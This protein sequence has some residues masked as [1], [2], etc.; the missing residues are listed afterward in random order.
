VSA[1]ARAFR[2]LFECAPVGLAAVDLS[3][4]VVAA[5]P[6]L[7]HLLGFSESALRGRAITDLTYPDDL[8]LT[9]QL[10][11]ELGAGLRASYSVEKRY[12]RA[13]G[14]AVKV[15]VTALLV[16]DP[17][18]G[19]AFVVGL[20]EPL[21]ELAQL[22][23]S[24]AE[25]RAT[26]HDFNN[27]LFVIVNYAEL[28]LRQLPAGE[29]ARSEVEELRDAAQKATALIRRVFAVRDTEPARAETLDVNKVILEMR[30]LAQNLVGSNIQI[31]LRLDPSN[32]RV[33]AER[34]GFERVL[35]NIAANSRDAM[36]SGGTFSVETR[37]TGGAVE[38]V[39]SDTGPGIEPE[40]R[41]RIFDRGVTTKTAVGG[42]GIGLANVRDYAEAAGGTIEVESQP[43]HGATF[44]LTL[45][46]VV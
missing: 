16:R 32:P 27:L 22:Q 24:V 43:G 44:T 2:T 38:I 5:N 12:V 1:Q 14:A 26:A 6:A 42:Q 45:P 4:Q 34:E 28:L 23:E 8:A 25:A 31:V 10:F 35:G 39:M 20:V 19:R 3:G 13:D 21:D 36:P 37:R 40:I 9:K 7:A 33:L 29:R 17:E 41:E 15:R 11:S 18:G 30:K 46:A